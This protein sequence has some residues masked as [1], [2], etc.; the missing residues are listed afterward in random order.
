MTRSLAGVCV[1]TLWVLGLT[2]CGS[3]T[4]PDRSFAERAPATRASSPT[5]SN[6]KPLAYINGEAVTRANMHRPLL[7][8]AGGRVLAELALNRLVAAR[9]NQ[10]AIT[11]T[12]PMIEAERKLVLRSLAE[13]ENQSVVLLNQLRRRRGLGQARFQALLKRNAGLRQLVKDQVNVTDTAIRRA[14]Q[15]QYG[16]RYE[17]RI[18]VT[19][20]ARQT[21]QLRQKITQG[22]A[23]FATLAARHSTDPSATQGGLLSPISPADPSY[24]QAIRKAL[25]SLKV[26]AVS[27]VIGIQGGYAI[28]TLERKI[29]AASVKLADVKQALR[30]QV[31]QRLERQ[32]MRQRARAMLREANVVV[33]N[34]ALGEAWRQHKRGLLEPSE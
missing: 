22:R 18:L 30:P 16:P 8:A 34:P 23:D 3:T 1:V 20:S 26:G 13:D 28:L 14:Y 27:D 12:D 11:L 15:L 19:N 21:Q 29:E 17:G 5:A 33:L 25:T 4:G 6:N 7:E 32:R 2:G 9:L 31:R 10:Q 24:P